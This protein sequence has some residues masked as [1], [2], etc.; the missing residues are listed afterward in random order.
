MNS[1]NKGAV[2]EREVAAL[3][4]TWWSK[5]EPGCQFVRT[6][7][8]GGWAT[9]ELRG[10]F[11]A[12]GDLMTTAK[13]FPFAIEVK[14]REGWTLD[15]L[16]AGK[17][18]PVWGWWKQCQKAANEMQKVPCMWF[19]KSKEGWFAMLP[20][21]GDPGVRIGEPLFSFC[22]EELTKVDYG[23]SLPAIYPAWKLLSWTPA[24]FSAAKP[25]LAKRKS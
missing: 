2:A 1:R 7:S 16:V 3:L 13:K 20:V 11:Q 18:S 22:T 8:S 23:I 9:P 14:R 25:S 21:G 17:S 5:F 10:E 19:R 24:W 6:P 15:R 12:A 4:Q